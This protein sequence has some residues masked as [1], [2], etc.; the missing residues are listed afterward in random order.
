MINFFLD[1][2]AA[3]SATI[4]LLGILPMAGLIVAGGLSVSGNPHYALTVGLGTLLG[5]AI[6]GYNTFCGFLLQGEMGGVLGMAIGCLFTLIALK[7]SP[8]WVKAMGWIYKHAAFVWELTSLVSFMSIF[9]TALFPGNDFVSGAVSFAAN[10]FTA[11]PLL[12][13]LVNTAYALNVMSGNALPIDVKVVFKEDT[14]KGFSSMVRTYKSLILM[15]G[16]FSFLAVLGNLYYGVYD[17][18]AS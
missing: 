2:Y 15:L 6:G 17:Y 4:G 10:I 11:F 18:F 7:E 16:I 9:F 3:A 14:M 5:V 1:T 13:G 8:G 12:L